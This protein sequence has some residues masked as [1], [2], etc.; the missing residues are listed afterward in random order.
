MI[1]TCVIL[2]KCRLLIF[3]NIFIIIFVKYIE[4]LLYLYHKSLKSSQKILTLPSIVEYKTSNLYG[5]GGALKIVWQV[6]FL[7][8][9]IHVQWVSVWQ[10]I[11]IF[12]T[13]EIHFSQRTTFQLSLNH[14]STVSIS[15]NA[16]I[17]CFLT[18]IWKCASTGDV[19]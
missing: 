19:L 12:R 8:V 18:L 6:S 17:G 13:G 2:I 4:K 5:E 3:F 15:F 14:R 7:L 11:V 16:A 10:Q 9:R 1:Y